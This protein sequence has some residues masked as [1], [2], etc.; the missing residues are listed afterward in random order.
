MDRSV[1]FE[2]RAEATD[3]L[4]GLKAEITQNGWSDGTIMH[5]NGADV[6][7]LYGGNGY[8]TYRLKTVEQH[9]GRL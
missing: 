6:H 1:G 4:R 9:S 8:V 3:A 5:I 7:V 2:N